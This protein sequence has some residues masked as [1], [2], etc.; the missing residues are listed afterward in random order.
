ME[1]G[2]RVFSAIGQNDALALC[3]AWLCGDFD[4]QED[5]SPLR[6]SAQLGI[7]LAQAELA[8]GWT[9]GEEKLKFAQLAAAQGERNGLYWLGRFFLRGDGCEKDLSKAKENFLLASA[10]SCFGD[11]LAWL[12]FSF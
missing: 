3:F 1:D 7:A 6:R 8:A 5:L 10:W 9:E 4:E 11:E 12:V 2:K